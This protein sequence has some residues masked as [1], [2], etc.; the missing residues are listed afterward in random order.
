MKGL[1]DS[2]KLKDHWPHGTCILLSELKSKMELMQQG[3]MDW[4]INYPRFGG[5]AG[6]NESF[7][8]NCRNNYTFTLQIYRSNCIQWDLE[9]R[10]WLI[11]EARILE[12]ITCYLYCLQMYEK[13]LS[14]L[15]KEFNKHRVVG[16]HQKLVDMASK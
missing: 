16:I 9:K 6:I 10:L 15:V 13:E 7:L 8:E 5:M 4:H 12:K 3:Q 14:Y 11:M 1:F 2:Q